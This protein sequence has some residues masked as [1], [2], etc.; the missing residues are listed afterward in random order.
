MTSALDQALQLKR[1]GRL[2]EAVIALESVLGR[3]PHDGFALGHLAEVQ[4]R[5]GRV[6][7]AA[8]ALEKAEEATGTTAFTARLR[9][10]LLVK[11]GDYAGASRAYADAVALG[12]PG[13]WSLVRLARCRLRTKDFEGVR[14]AASE[15]VERDPTSAQAWTVL[16]DL[17]LR[18]ARLDDA[19]T[20]YGRAHE[21]APT[22]KWAYAKLVETRLRRLPA[23][24]REREIQVLLKTTGRNNE[25]L[26]GV[27]ARLRGESGDDEAAARTWS[28][29]AGRTGDLFA[30]EQAGFALR[31]AGRLADAAQ[32]LGACLVEDPDNVILFRTYVRMQ[33]ERGALED[34]RATLGAALDRASAR[35]RGA[36]LG[37]LRKLPTPEDPAPANPAEG[38][39]EPGTAGQR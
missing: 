21:H 18:E 9:G 29:R 1:S 12:E 22:D 7:D 24:R 37:Q 20:M 27:L 25:H 28:E 13:T 36:Y 15:A 26:L 17:A 33:H 4:L 16:G 38:G 14:G 35:R 8:A 30:R 6:D 10:D 39:L 3:A 5:R 31:R 19:E 34:L 2:D 11:A 23:D 32:T